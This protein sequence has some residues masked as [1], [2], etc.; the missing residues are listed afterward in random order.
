MGSRQLTVG[1]NNQTTG[2]SGVISDCGPT[3]NEC[4]ATLANS[5][6]SL[7][8]AGTGTLTLSGTN[9]YTGAT[10]VDDG[11]LIVDGSIATSSGLTVDAGGTVGGT[12]TLPTTV[13]N[14]TLAPG[15]S[16][17]TITVAGNLTFGAGS[18][19][20]VEVSPAAADRTN[21]TGSATLAGIVQATFAS[22]TYVTRQHTIL[23]ADGGLGGTTFA[24][25][26]TVAL[27][28]GLAAALSYGTN[29]VFL[30]LTAQLG[31][32]TA[33]LGGN[34]Q[35]VAGAI[36]SYFNGGGALPP[37]F[38]PLFD[39]NGGALSSALSQLSGEAT[40]GAQQAGAQLTNQFL[41]LMLDPFAVGRGSTI[42]GVPGTGSALAL[43]PESG[44]PPEAALAF[45]KVKKAPPSTAPAAMA[46]SWSAWGGPFGGT[47]KI[48]GDA[49][50]GSSDLRTNTG[51]FAAGI[52][53]LVA[54]DTV[55]GFALAGGVTKWDIAAGLGGGSSDAFQAGA[56]A[57][58]RPGRGTSPAL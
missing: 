35:N 16:I 19:Y 13:I 4:G 50:T 40:T 8:K 15:N 26:S 23:H 11:G 3:S 22:G 52:D 57:V 58:T 37:G 49:S 31:L 53:Y 39:L 46:P 17:G 51:G 10:Q 29:D 43:A 54:P 47:G 28:A 48:E 42:G 38:L 2:V 9:T 1:G 33:G 21:A 30:D 32:D 18:I 5:G 25:L 34:Q 56:Y 20:A 45:A 36:N 55:V 7:I 41:S 14:G 24:S 44:L 12:G 6:G 27:P